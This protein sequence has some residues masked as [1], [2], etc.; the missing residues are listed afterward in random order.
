V[1]PEELDP[2]PEL[3]PPLEAPE[4]PPEELELLDEAPPEPPDE[5]APDEE[6]LEE[7]PE[8]DPLPGGSAMSNGLELKP[9]HPVRRAVSSTAQPRA[10]GNTLARACGR[11]ELT[12]V[13]V[14]LGTAASPC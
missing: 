3:E 1:T 8:E 14:L 7:P 13:A 2:A 10:A 12:L 11:D 9:P 5:E 4:L 6:P